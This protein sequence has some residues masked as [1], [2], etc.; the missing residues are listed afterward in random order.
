MSKKYGL[1]L[2]SK[3]DP[4]PVIR[5]KNIFDEDAALESDS[6][7]EMVSSKIKQVGP[8]KPDFLQAPKAHKVTDRFGSGKLKKETKGRIEKALEED[9]NAFAYDEVY[10]EMKEDKQK[11]R[12]TK[13]RGE[14][15]YIANLLKSA[16]ARKIEE[17]RRTD[18]KIE[19]ER[20]E[21]GNEF[22]DKEIFVT[23]AYKQKLMERKI[24][25]EKERREK[26][27]EGK[28]MK[29]NCN[30]SLNCFFFL[31]RTYGREKTGRHGRFL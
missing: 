24:F 26:Q 19:K 15:K 22:D 20:Q 9:P 5:R 11:I 27:L 21:E 14:S 12:G 13:V 17:Q 23:E 18:R 3:D 8:S 7:E 2:R 29:R 4:H 16:E 10:E 31:N 1:V 6:S 28:T 25:E 30:I